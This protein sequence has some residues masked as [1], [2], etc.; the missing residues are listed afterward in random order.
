MSIPLN[1]YTQIR[2]YFL[3]RA[4]WTWKT[5]GVKYEQVTYYPR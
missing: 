5:E 1:C 4:P 2:N 3:R